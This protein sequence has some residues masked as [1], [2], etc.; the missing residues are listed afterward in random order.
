MDAIA[1]DVAAVSRIEVVPSLLEIVCRTTGM[2]FAAVARVTIDRWVACGVHDDIPFG[3]EPGGELKVE[4][5]I[6]N[7]PF[8]GV[9]VAHPRDIAASNS[10]RARAT[11]SA[12]RCSFISCSLD[13]C[14]PDFTSRALLSAMIW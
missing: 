4:T 3:L 10:L 14:C 5:T 12:A 6:C 11:A 1:D 2:R 8:N 13:G 9:E 7:D